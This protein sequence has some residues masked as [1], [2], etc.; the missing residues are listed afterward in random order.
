MEDWG[1]GVNIWAT[2][3]HVP[4]IERFLVIATTLPFKIYSP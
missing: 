1:I 2:D 4:E 3:E